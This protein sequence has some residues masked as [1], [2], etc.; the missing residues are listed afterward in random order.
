MSNKEEKSCASTS[1]NWYPGQKEK[2]KKQ[3]IEDL[4]MI[5]IAI[6]IV[7]ARIPKASKNPHME[8]YLK[9]KN[10][11]M[12]LN[13]SD[14]ADE[15]TTQEWIDYYKKNNIKA[16]AIEAN[17]GK[18]INQVTNEIKSEYNKIQEKYNDKGRI[19]HTIKVM[20]LGI[21]N[22][23]KSTFINSL[24]KKNTAKVENRPGVTRNKQWIKIDN[25]IDLMDTPGMLWPKLDDGETSLHLA[26]TNSIGQTAIDSEEIAY[27]LL[28]FLI[29][30]YPTNVEN[31]YGIKIVSTIDEKN[32]EVTDTDEQDM[33]NVESD[34]TLEIRDTIARKKGCILSGGRI[35]EQKISDMI[36]N[37]F[38]SGK[39]G[40]IS[41]ESPEY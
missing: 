7:D 36:L 19:G 26:F 28:K 16:I 38:Q 3:I 10:R 23:G 8:Q 18:G 9:N 40:K 11:I 35:N 32:V 14:L 34:Q 22:V 13:K 1:I 33:Y 29:E 21:P 12:I 24:S 17:S 6:E 27:Y 2:T 5:D 25:N 41:L 15:K 39:L 20:I 37:D 31:R 30:N 4:K